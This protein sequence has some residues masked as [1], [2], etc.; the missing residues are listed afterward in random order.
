[1]LKDYFLLGFKNVKRRGIRSWLTLLGIFIGIAAVVS[2][3]SLGSGLKLA[4]NSQFGVST[5]EVI[6]VQAGGVVGFGAPGSGAVTPL[7]VDDAEAIEKISLVEKVIPRNIPSVK[8]EFNDEVYFGSAMSVPDKEDRKFVYEQLDIEPEVGRLLKDGDTSRVVLGYNFYIETAG[9][10]ERIRPGNTILLQDKEFKVI[11][12]TKKKGS[13]IMDNVIYVNEKPLQDLIGSEDE[14]DMIVVKVKDRDV[15]D[16]AKEEIEK[17]L[18]KTRDV[19]K[20]EEDF[21]VSTPQASLETVNQIL[22]GIQV[23]VVLIAFV[24]IVVG[25]IGIINTMTTSVLER[26]AEIGVMKAIGAKNSDIFLQFFIE[27]G[28]L[29]LIGGLIGVI[30]G[31]MIGYIGTIKINDFIGSSVKPEINFFLIMFAL[32]GSFLI[33]SVSGIAPAIKAAKQNPVEALRD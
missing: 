25:A 23:F 19:K 10:E 9:F 20:G 31:V 24:S 1:M 5:T 15:M 12:I 16:K 2:L 4:V 6:I 33:G 14:I 30:A 11:G 8:I 22:G 28:F 13:F 32:I 27:A 17:V 21:I 18:R 3:I 29:G 7:T 26:K